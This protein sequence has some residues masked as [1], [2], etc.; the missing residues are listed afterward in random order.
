MNVNTFISSS[1]PAL[2]HPANTLLGFNFLSIII[3]VFS[4]VILKARK[5][6]ITLNSF[7]KMNIYDD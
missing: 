7:N 5:R 6:E 3:F 2:H 4:E 1:Q